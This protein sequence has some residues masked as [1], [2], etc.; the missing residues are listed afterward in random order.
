MEQ[1]MELAAFCCMP[2]CQ[3]RHIFHAPSLAFL[4]VWSHPALCQASAVV[5]NSLAV[6]DASGSLAHHY[7][8]THLFGQAKHELFTPGGP[9][10]LTTSTLQVR[11]THQP[12]AHSVSR[13]A[14]SL[15]SQLSTWFCIHGLAPIGYLG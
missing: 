8:K 13:L 9:G 15:E 11:W 3:L 14:H 10:Q 4:H 6:F 1:L 7:R 2:A 5:Y 12:T